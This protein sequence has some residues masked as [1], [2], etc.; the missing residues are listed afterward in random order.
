MLSYVFIFY[1]LIVLMSRGERAPKKLRFY[2]RIS[3]ILIEL[4]PTLVEVLIQ[5][6]ENF[7][8]RGCEND[9]GKLRQK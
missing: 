8:V 9:A 1:W 3:G 7:F 5:S 4:S 2:G 6:C